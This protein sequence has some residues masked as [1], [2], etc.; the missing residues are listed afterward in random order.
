MKDYSDLH[1]C[2]KH[3]FYLLAQQVFLCPKFEF[4]QI[5]L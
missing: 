2:V 1:F 3:Y 5:D 4:K